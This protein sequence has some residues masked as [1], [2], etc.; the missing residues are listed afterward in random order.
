MATF[1]VLLLTAAPPGQSG[2]AGGALVKIDARESLLRCVEL[3]VNRDNVKQIQICF[4]PDEIEQAKRKYAA[5]LSFTGVKVLAGGPKW[6][7]QI[8]AAGPKI[9]EE[10]THVIVHDAARPAVAYSDIDALMEEAEKHP[11]IVLITPMRTPLVEIDEGGN[12]V[13][14]H[15]ADRFVQL[16]TPQVYSKAKFMEIVSGRQ[17]LHPSQMRL[18]K[19]SPLN[20]RLAGSGD[21]TLVRAMLNLLPKPK[22]KPPTSP[23]E[24][25][26]W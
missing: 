22:V 25:A 14:V 9:A 8:A 20:V 24:E 12:P 16:L 18:L 19:G 10:C 5:H 17:A 13:A 4:L 23:F 7:D 21:V 26:Q 11:A 3:F 15:P 6:H 1:S 2:E